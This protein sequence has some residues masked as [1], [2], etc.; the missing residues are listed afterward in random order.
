[1]LE[2]H[3]RRYEGVFVSL[4]LAKPIRRVIRRPHQDGRKPS[5]VHHQQE[6]KTPGK[7]AK[8]KGREVSGTSTGMGEVQNSGSRKPSAQNGPAAASPAPLT[9]SNLA[10]IDG[11]KKYTPRRAHPRKTKDVVW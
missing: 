4:P 7:F 1:M 8:G 6:R 9:E 10:A 11:G 3:P 5:G 2:I